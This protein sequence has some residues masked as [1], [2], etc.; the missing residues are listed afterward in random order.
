LDNSINVPI[1]VLLSNK[2]TDELRQEM[3]RSEVFVVCR[4]GNDS[5][6]AVRYLSEKVNVK[7][8]KDLVGGLHA[9]ARKV[10]ENFPIY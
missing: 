8:A 4:R 1:K 6:L 10:D 2:I 5:Q 7:R 9:W 3:T